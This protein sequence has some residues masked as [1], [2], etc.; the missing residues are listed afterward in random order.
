MRINHRAAVWTAFSVMVLTCASGLQAQD[1]QDPAGDKQPPEKTPREQTWE[2]L[3]ERARSEVQRLEANKRRIATDLR[4][5]IE[6][7][8]QQ[9]QK[10]VEQIQQQTQKQ[11][12]MVE[13]QAREALQRLTD[14]QERLKNQASEQ[15]QRLQARLRLLP[16][17]D[18]ENGPAVRRPA[19]ADEKLDRILERLDRLEKRLDRLE[20]RLPSRQP[21]D[22]G[23]PAERPL[24]DGDGQ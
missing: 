19:P 20:R 2:Q 16:E 21:R 17:S 10:Q 11:V 12:E 7:L 3:R 14:E 23:G 22:R 6:Q 5:Q 15:L 8:K 4:S 1:P 24:G 9:S 13:A 18:R